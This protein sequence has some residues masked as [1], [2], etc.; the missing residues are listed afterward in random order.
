[1]R[2]IGSRLAAQKNIRGA[3]RLRRSEP[4][5]LASHGPTSTPG[6]MRGRAGA[7]WDPLL[8]TGLV[9]VQIASPCPA[10]FV[11]PKKGN[12][13]TDRAIILSRLPLGVEF[14]KSDRRTSW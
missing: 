12:A 4:N 11:L 1:M 14:T 6:A 9:L 10:Q 8:A 7:I 13:V 5:A 2:L 3:R